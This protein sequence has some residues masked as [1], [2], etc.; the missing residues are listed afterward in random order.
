MSNIPRVAAM[1]TAA[2]LSLSAGRAAA[3]AAQSPPQCRNLSYRSNFRLNGADRYLAQADH[4]AYAS[5]K[6]RNINDALR[7]LCDAARAGGA[8]AATLWFMY[9]RAYALNNDL[10]GADSAW[11]RAYGLTDPDCQREI[12]RLRQNAAAPLLTAA[13]GLVGE[14]RNDSA[15]VVLRRANQVYRSDPAGF[16]YTAS[17]FLTKEQQDTSGHY[18]DSAAWYFR[19]ASKAGDAPARAS[20]RSLAAFNAARL[21]ERGRQFAVAE[22]VYRD[23]LATAPGDVRARAGLAGTLQGQNHPEQAAAIYDSILSS[24]DSID[25]FTLFELGVSLFRQRRYDMAARSIE[26]G[27]AKNPY[28]RDA[29]FNLTNAYLAGSDTVKEL[30]AARR[31][32]QVDPNNR[33]SLALLAGGYQRVASSHRGRGERAIAAGDTASVRRIRPVIQAYQDSTLAVLT[34]ADSLPWEIAVQ[35]FDTRDTAITLRGAVVNLKDR[36]LPALAL[37]IEFLDGRGQVVATEHVD[38]P[39]LNPQGQPGASYDFTITANGRGILAYR[40]L[41]S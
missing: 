5:D 19:L 31:L 29:L 3:Q 27:L 26:L 14:G 40:Y 36:E 22:S 15:L 35:A 32:V 24:A 20:L 2:L 9:G 34:R 13:V 4:A 17:V 8:D 16:M 1:L 30:D 11:T 28:N 10:V 37:T 7:V 12:L 25:S 39:T 41:T 23:Y 33:T 6:Q 18:A 38:V 21:L